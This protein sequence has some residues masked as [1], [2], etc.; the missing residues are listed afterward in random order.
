MGTSSKAPCQAG[1][2]PRSRPG[3]GG[4]LRTAEKHRYLF[5]HAPETRLSPAESSCAELPRSF[6]M[7]LLSFSSSFLFLFLPPSVGHTC[8]EGCNNGLGKALLALKSSCD[9]NLIGQMK[10][11]REDIPHFFLFFFLFL[12]LKK[13]QASDGQR[14]ST[15]VFIALL[16]K[17][18]SHL[19]MRSL[20]PSL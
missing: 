8:N 2:A 5:I 3:S 19:V 20:P 14:R 1:T 18:S 15:L 11:F 16:R 6:F 12:T 4:H 10:R 9:R 13:K 17:G 7:S